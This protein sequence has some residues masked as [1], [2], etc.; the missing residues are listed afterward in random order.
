MPHAKLLVEQ[1]LPIAA[2][3]AECMRDQSAASV[4]CVILKATLDYQA[5]FGPCLTSEIRKYGEL[6]AKKVCKRLALQERPTLEKATERAA[7]WHPNRPDSGSLAF[8][9]CCAGAGIR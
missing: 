4:A 7:R 6:W 9:P 3:G 1:W 5:R 2:I 8:G